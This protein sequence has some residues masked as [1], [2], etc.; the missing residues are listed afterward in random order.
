MESTATTANV[1]AAACEVSAD[2]LPA[3]QQPEAAVGVESE[4]VSAMDF[5]DDLP[6]L[7]RVQHVETADTATAVDASTETEGATVACEAKQGEVAM[8][9]G[10]QAEE[11]PVE[12]VQLNNGE[13]LI[14]DAEQHLASAPP[15][16]MPP[17]PPL[18]SPPA[19]QQPAST[20]PAV[21]SAA[22]AATAAVG[23]EPCAYVKP[24]VSHL[25]G[26]AASQAAIVNR[27][28]AALYE[29]DAVAVSRWV[30]AATRH[31]KAQEETKR[32]MTESGQRIKHE[33]AEFAQKMMQWRG[34]VAGGINRQRAQQ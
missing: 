23:P 19:S 16:A 9:S 8:E 26:Y 12:A 30:A 17:P 1:F 27:Y 10:R 2:S 24:L 5:A 29:F 32:E 13:E 15:A 14:A 11:Q 33:I 3:S 4:S 20:P 34:G 22:S 18:L 6:Q 7:S 21:D 25:D 28:R 31:L